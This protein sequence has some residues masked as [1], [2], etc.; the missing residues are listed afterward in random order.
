[1]NDL[2]TLA[3][4]GEADITP[5]KPAETVG[6]FRPS[7][8]SRG[9]AEPLK[10][11]VFAWQN[12]GMPGCL[13]AIDSLGFTT[14]LAD[15]LRD[16]IASIIGSRRENVMLCFSHTHSAPNAATVPGYFEFAGERISEAVREAVETAV[17]IKAGWGV[18]ECV[19]GVNRRS[20]GSGC[21]RRLGLLKI[22]DY[23]GGSRLLV[24]RVTAHANVLSSDNYML[25][26]D[27]F[28]TAR[29][30]IAEKF[31]CPVI[32]IQ[33]AAG[34]VRPRFRQH[35]A[36]YLEIHSFEAA[37]TVVPEAEKQRCLTESRQAMRDMSA[38][39]LRGTE[40]AAV[41]MRDIENIGINSSTMNC[42]ANVPDMDRALKI[43]EEAVEAGIDGTAWL[44]EVRKLNN[45]GVK[46]QLS[47]VELQIFRLN[48]GCFCGIAN[49]AMCELALELQRRMRNPL[50]FLN[51]YTNGC[52]SYL[53]TAEEYDAGG[54]EVLWSNLIYYRY[55]GR[56]MP[57]NRET[58]G[59]IVTLLEQKLNALG[60]IKK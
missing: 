25:S 8:L 7:N 13:A 21:D 1:M 30:L 36:D 52:N 48:D 42:R 37:Q 5:A 59:E 16:R 28:G 19:I 53:P 18:A 57:F 6:F 58:A 39:I 43:A 2:I 33:G 45:A 55:H 44:A 12:R 49:E 22:T 17:P 50:V 46:A 56:V 3:G 40:S 15:L 35:N 29:N 51:G 34:N 9:V 11:Q 47:P 20:G 10:A 26:P 32:M 23:E 60:G 54:Y 4:Y 31:G 27:Y 38:E 41:T 14:K 24:L